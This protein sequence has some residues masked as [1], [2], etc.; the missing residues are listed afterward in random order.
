MLSTTYAGCSVTSRLMDGAGPIVGILV[1]LAAWLWLRFV[2]QYSPATRAFF[3]LVFAFAAFWNVGYMCKSG[4]FDQG[5]W[6]FVIQGLEPRLPWHLGLAALGLLLYIAA[7]RACAK[8]LVLQ[9]SVEG[10]TPLRFTA[11]AYGSAAL[12][13]AAGAAFDPRGP[14]TIVSD[15]LPSSLGAI[16]LLLAGLRLDQ[17]NLRL[18]LPSSPSW[19]MIG[20][21]SA[22]V[23]AAVLGPGL[24]F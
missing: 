8:T 21:L 14:F 19:I 13:S 18:S 17:T 6:A 12:L 5:D 22:V 15:A 24:H 7:I 16:G 11:V 20:S 23:F 1:A 4:L 9:K 10:I 2:P 3:C